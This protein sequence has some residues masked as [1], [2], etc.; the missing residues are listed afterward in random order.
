MTQEENLWNKRILS[1][2]EAA[3]KKPHADV[4]L[5]KLKNG[6]LIIGKFISTQQSNETGEWSL[7]INDEKILF[8]D[9]YTVE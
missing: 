8:G 4:I 3:R 2:L 6:K 5:V 7:L 1:H 9:I